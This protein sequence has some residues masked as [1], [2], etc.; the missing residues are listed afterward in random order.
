AGYR[1]RP[2]ANLDAVVHA[3]VAVQDYVVAQAGRVIEIDINPL[4][5]TPTGAVAADALIRL[6]EET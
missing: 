4:I 2:P 6:R 3:S 1:G 5:A